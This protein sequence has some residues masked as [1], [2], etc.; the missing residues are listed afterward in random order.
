MSNFKHGLLATYAGGK[1]I[2]WHATSNQ[3]LSRYEE[4][5]NDINTCDFT[6]DGK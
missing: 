5:G 1:C 2:L 3:V 6:P 4:Q